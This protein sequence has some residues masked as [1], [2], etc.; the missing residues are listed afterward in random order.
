MT[1]EQF[2]DWRD[3]GKSSIPISP[4]EILEAQ[5]IPDEEIRDMLQDMRVSEDVERALGDG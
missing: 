3:P 1:H 4:R 2:P 5:D